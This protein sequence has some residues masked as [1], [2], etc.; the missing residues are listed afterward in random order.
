[1]SSRWSLR[2][3]RHSNTLP[4]L[5]ELFREHRSDR[6]AEA[7]SY[8]RQELPA[9]DVTGGLSALPPD[10]Q[11]L[12]R[13]LS[14]FYDNLG[15]LVAHDIVDIDPV[16]GY[17]GGSVLETWDTLQPLIEGERLRRV[18]DSDASRWQEY[19]ENMAALL[20]DCS[21]ETA[22]RRQRNWILQASRS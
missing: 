1:M 4:V 15:A 16:A 13:D 22:R 8:V 18:N 14:W 20:R 2:L 21:P 6:L 5:V 12:V 3:S 11:K 7:R 10:K 17:L 19:F 9:I